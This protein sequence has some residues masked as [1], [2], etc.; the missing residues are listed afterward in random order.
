[1]VVGAVPEMVMEP[2]M[3]L[4][5][6]RLPLVLLK[7]KMLLGVILRQLCRHRVVVFPP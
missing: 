3:V 2:L 4:S 7:I 1:M 6:A 5:T